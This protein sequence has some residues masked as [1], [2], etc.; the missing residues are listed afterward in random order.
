MAEGWALAP[1]VVMS[2]VDWSTVPALSATAK[3]WEPV[4]RSASEALPV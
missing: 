4:V 3:Y 1:A 2:M